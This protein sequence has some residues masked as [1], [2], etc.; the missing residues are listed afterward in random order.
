VDSSAPDTPSGRGVGV[1]KIPTGTYR[2]QLRPEFTFDD[3]T[4]VLPYEPVAPE[5]SRS[6]ALPVP[7]TPAG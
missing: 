1:H 5:P 4:A 7:V 6:L 2:L 3:A